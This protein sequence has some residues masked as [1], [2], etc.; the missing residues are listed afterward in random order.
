MQNL[1]LS[2]IFLLAYLLAFGLIT[3]NELRRHFSQ[4]SEGIEKLADEFRT[5]VDEHPDLNHVDL[6]VHSMR[7]GLIP[8][9]T[10]R[11][12]REDLRALKLQSIMRS[13]FSEQNLSDTVFI[14][15]EQE[16]HDEFAVQRGFARSK[17]S[18]VPVVKEL[19][20]TQGWDYIEFIP[21]SGNWYL[22][23]RRFGYELFEPG[24]FKPDNE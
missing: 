4:H 24:P 9:E 1:L 5:A 10:I 20:K 13:D 19:G 14:M 8:K 2:L 6:L 18:L 16:D 21:I 3:D 7:S 17:S 15:A 11:K 23:E 12:I 22:Y